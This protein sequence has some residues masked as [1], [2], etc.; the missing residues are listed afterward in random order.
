MRTTLGA[1]AG[2]WT[3]ILLITALTVAV[4]AAVAAVVPRQY[5]ASTDL[6]L[7]QV[8]EAGSAGSP[9]ERAIASYAAVL[10]GRTLI[11]STEGA[12]DVEV[13]A[14]PREGADVIR[15]DVRA[16]TARE[17][18][19]AATALGNRF[20]AWLDLEQPEAGPQVSSQVISPAGAPDSP[21]RPDW[22]TWLAIA[23]VVGLVVGSVRAV[24]RGVPPGVVD[25]SAQAKEILGAPVLASVATDPDV[26]TRPLLSD[27]EPHHPRH[28]AL[29]ILRTN[30]QFLDVDQAQQVITVTSAL[31]GDGK[32]TTTCALAQAIAE[33]GRSVV[34]VE[35]DLRRP[36]LAEMFGIE[37]TVGLTTALVGRIPIDEAVQASGTPGLD[38]LTSGALPPNPTEI[39]QTTAMARL[40]DGL[41]DRYDVV[42]IDAPPLL[43]VSD[44]ALLAALSDGAIVLVRHGRTRADEL[45]LAAERLRAVDATVL[46]TVL[47]MTPR[48]EARRYGYGPEGSTSSRQRG[49]RRAAR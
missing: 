2:R 15:L 12:T 23:T 7:L 11:G 22:P 27:L 35:G 30:L 44:A 38:V 31:P 36:R 41:R 29:R 14:T 34:V 33:T 8:D 18:A 43:P 39:L 26:R 10:E 17:A 37:R 46:G 19:A 47:T 49:T 24:F 21:S 6:L 32:T 45:E 16:D 40:V 1:I 9:G 28:E 48:R 3:S 13:R 5:T 42:L 20:A 4:V 25:T